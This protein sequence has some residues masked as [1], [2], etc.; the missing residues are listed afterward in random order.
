MARIEN[1]FLKLRGSMG[2]MTF[3]QDEFGTIAKKKATDSKG[4]REGTRRGNMEMGGG[5]MAAKDLRLAL[6]LK[7]NGIKDQYFSGRLSG[8]M[9]KIVLLGTGM[10]G[11]RKLDIRKNGSLLEGFEFINAR[12]LVYS[13]GGIK[14]KPSLNKERNE[15]R[16]SSPILNRKEQITAPEGATH[17]SFKL[18][19]GTVSNYGYNVKKKKY[20]A[21]E[22]GFKNISAISESEPLP[23]NKK[24]IAPVN[25]SVNLT[26]ASAIPEEV[27]V[28]TF[29]GVSF[30]KN[31]NGELLGIEN[32][33]GMR[34]LGVC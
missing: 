8:R 31:V 16:W 11:Q 2:G 32:V 34:V 5:S 24:I 17:I 30:Y 7:K 14:E 23:L 6:R 9:R 3:T 15:V 25:L 19:A 18:G 12:P 29:V 4:P 21:L 28:V 22:Q 33:G 26:G 13:V 27:A 1:D 10:V 20:V